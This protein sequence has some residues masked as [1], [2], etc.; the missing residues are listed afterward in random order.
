MCARSQRCTCPMRRNRNVVSARRAAPRTQNRERHRAEDQT[1]RSAADRAVRRRRFAEKPEAGRQSLR[2][3]SARHREATPRLSPRERRAATGC[4]RRYR[5]SCASGHGPELSRKRREANGADSMTQP[6]PQGSTFPKPLPQSAL[7]RGKLSRASVRVAITRP[8]GSAS[9][10]CVAGAAI[11]SRVAGSRAAAQIEGAF[12]SSA[13]PAANLRAA[14]AARA[15]SGAN[16]SP[17]C[18]RIFTR[19][20]MPF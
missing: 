14:T 10:V 8:R 4:A 3:E 16:T 12:I 17:G 13:R 6:I 9:V 11:R 5:F 7:R 2:M 18:G 1:E 20:G 15:R 19:A